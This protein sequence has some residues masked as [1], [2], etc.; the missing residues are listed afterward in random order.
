MNDKE[1]CHMEIYKEFAAEP[2]TFIHATKTRKKTV[3]D[4]SSYKNY[5]EEE[6]FSDAAAR[7]PELLKDINKHIAISEGYNIEFIKQDLKK[8]HCIISH[9]ESTYLESYYHE[10]FIQVLLIIFKLHSQVSQRIA[11]RA[12]QIV[13]NLYY[14]L[15]SF[16]TPIVQPEFVEKVIKFAD[17]PATEI[18]LPTFSALGNYCNI[19]IEA[20]DILIHFD[21][22]SKL[23]RFMKCCTRNLHTKEGL[24][25][26]SNLMAYEYTEELWKSIW[27]LIPVFRCHLMHTFIK[28]RKSSAECLISVMEFPE[29][30]DTCVEFGVQNNLVQLMIDSNQYLPEM[31]KAA[32]CFISKGIVDVFLNEEIYLSAIDLLE[33][34]QD[35]DFAQLLFFFGRLCEYSWQDIYRCGLMLAICQ[36]QINGTCESKTAAAYCLIQFMR[37]AG[38]SEIIEIG[39]NGGFELLVTT[40]PN[41]SVKKMMHV[42]V[43]IHSLLQMNEEF[44]QI[45]Q[46]INIG[47]YFSETDFSSSEELF[48]LSEEIYS[49]IYEQDK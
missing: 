33:H 25:L 17:N 10:D 23:E 14:F 34:E 41:L 40:I 22:T 30:V 39:I 45:A 38:S 27:I 37:F 2:K 32:I 48:L 7:I 12:L 8:M 9:P 5:I 19:S 18:W 15:D 4:A 43:A 1:K 28:T 35:Q 13:S 20:R 47:E 26:A 21:V 49:L 16:H 24:R 42:L 11:I 36:T 3:Y 44:S 6:Q 29:G 46:R 31:Y